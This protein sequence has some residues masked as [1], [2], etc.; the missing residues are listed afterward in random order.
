MELEK[1]TRRHLEG[2]W[3]KLQRNWR[4][5]LRIIR[6]GN[7]ESRRNLGSKRTRNLWKTGEE[8]ERIWKRTLRGWYKDP[9]GNFKIISCNFN[10]ITLPSSFQIPLFHTR[11]FLLFLAM[12]FLNSLKV[13][14]PQNPCQILYRAPSLYLSSSHTE[15]LLGRSQMH[16]QF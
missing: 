7:L 6:E 14:S 15:F 5:E 4:K 3:Y 13:R 8:S 1:R 12:F 2:Y 9:I 11:Y 10:S 16:S